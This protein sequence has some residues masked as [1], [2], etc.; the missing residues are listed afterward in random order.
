[1]AESRCR[2]ASWN[3]DTRN[4]RHALS[5]LETDHDHDADE[6]GDAGAKLFQHRQG[7]MAE[8]G[9]GHDVVRAVVDFL[10]QTGE[11]AFHV[12][13]FQFD[14]GTDREMGAR[15]GLFA[16]RRAAKIHTGIEAGMGQTDEPDGIQIEHG[17]GSRVGRRHFGRIA[18]DE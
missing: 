14:A 2:T 16:Q 18:G 1:M 6:K 11:F 9:L 13:G 7:F 4:L 8:G 5:V 12:A 15:I 10:L 3:N 17:G